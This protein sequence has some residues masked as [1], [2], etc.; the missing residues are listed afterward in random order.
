VTAQGTE[1]KALPGRLRF[2]DIDQNSY[3]DLIA[4]FSYLDP[5]SST[6]TT[7]TNVYFNYNTTFTSE[8]KDYDPVRQLMPA[9]EDPE[10]IEKAM[11]YNNIAVQAGNNT[12]FVTFID[13]SSNGKLDVILQK[14]DANGVPQIFFLYNFIQNNNFY[15]KS[16][17]LNTA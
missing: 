6:Q 13:I 5:A 16:F 8:T 10:K 14:V 12:Q 9:T 4:T 7:Q 3:I 17:L 15:M 11:L 2:A 1:T